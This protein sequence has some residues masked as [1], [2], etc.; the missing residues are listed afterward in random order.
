M[1]LKTNNKDTKIIAKANRP[2]VE[3]ENHLNELESLGWIEQEK[4]HQRM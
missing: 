4:I 3:I 1:I 2:S